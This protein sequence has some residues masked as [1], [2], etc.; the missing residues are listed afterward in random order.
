MLSGIRLLQN[1]LSDLISSLLG[2]IS[3]VTLIYYILGII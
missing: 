2:G 1:V 3:V